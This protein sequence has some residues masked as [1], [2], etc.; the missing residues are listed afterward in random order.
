MDRIDIS[1][2]ITSVCWSNRQLYKQIISRESECPSP[3]VMC[4]L[5]HNSFEGFRGKEEDDDDDTVSVCLCI[6]LVISITIPSTL[7][8]LHSL[9]QSP[10]LSFPSLPFLCA[11]SHISIWRQQVRVPSNDYDDHT[12]ARQV[13]ASQAASS[14][15][16]TRAHPPVSILILVAD[17]SPPQHPS[18][19]PPPPPPIRT[20]F[21]VFTHKLC[22]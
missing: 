20:P 21:T 9:S 15:Y 12:S 4:S 10:C 19:P 2:I 1:I 14:R 7:S 13:T 5:M 16:L 6:L 11:Q 18:P 17:V 3:Q 8:P 22:W